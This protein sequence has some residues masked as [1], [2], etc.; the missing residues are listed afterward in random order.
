MFS[1]SL[2]LV[3]LHICEFPFKTVR[4]QN[5]RELGL[6]SHK[7]NDFTYTTAKNRSFYTIYYRIHYNFW[8]FKIIVVL[9]V[10]FSVPQD[11]TL[12]RQYNLPNYVHHY[13]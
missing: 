4:M 6:D 5:S 7:I 10:C 3:E 12:K 13:F 1:I 9:G 8:F 11:V 2:F